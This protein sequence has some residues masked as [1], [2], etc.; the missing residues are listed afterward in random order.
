MDSTFCLLL[1]RVALHT[2]PPRA[3]HSIDPTCLH[4]N[5]SLPIIL[6]RRRTRCW[7]G[8]H[9]I[10]SPVP[11]MPFS[12]HLHIHIL[13][14]QVTWDLTQL[15]SFSCISYATTFTHS[16]QTPSIL[17]LDGASPGSSYIM[18]R[19]GIAPPFL[20]LLTPLPAASAACCLSGTA[21][22]CLR[23]WRGTLK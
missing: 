7:C 10:P 9:N 23:S 21:V 8:L 20:P 11:F 4:S 1:S 12:S 19:V 2:R 6:R 13:P 18:V 17:K 5:L 22:S 15:F 16:I 3:P 14:C